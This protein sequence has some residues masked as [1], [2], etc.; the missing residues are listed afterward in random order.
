MHPDAL[1]L[2]T[3]RRCKHNNVLA[4]PVI[5]FCVVLAALSAACT[6][7]SSATAICLKDSDCPSGKCLA[8]ECVETADLPPSNV[9]ADSLNGPGDGQIGDADVSLAPC[10][11]AADCDGIVGGVGACAKWSC[12][13]GRC[14]PLKQADLSACKTA[15]TCPAAGFCS[16]GV[17]NATG[18]ICVDDNGCTID[19]CGNTGCVHQLFPKGTSCKPSGAACLVGACDSGGNCLGTVAPGFC[20]IDGVCHKQGDAAGEKPCSKCLPTT[21]TSKWTMHITGPCDDGDP[22]TTGEHCNASGICK[23]QPAECV[24]K[25]VCNLNACQPGVGCVSLALAG[26][27]TDSNPCTVD[28][29]CGSGECQPGAALNCDDANP[30]TKDSCALGFGC[31]HTPQPGPCAADADPCTEDACIGEVCIG[32]PVA[33]TCMIKGNCVPANGHPDGQPCLACKPD[34]SKSDWTA[35]NNE[36]CADGDACTVS[37]TC[38][39]GKCLGLVAVCEDKNPCTA[40]SCKADKGCVFSPIDASCSDGDACTKGDLCLAGGCAGTVLTPGTCDDGN[41]CTTDTCVAAFGCSNTPNAAPCSDGDPCTKFDACIAASCIA[42]SLICPCASDQECNDK[43]PCTVDTCV[44]LGCNNVPGTVLNCDDKNACTGPDLCNGAA[45]SG[46]AV[47]CDDK[48]PC[49]ADVCVAEVGCLAQPMQGQLCSDGNACT[50]ADVCIDGKC[51]GKLKNCDDGNACTLDACLAKSGQCVHDAFGDGTACPDDL[52]SCTSDECKSGVC[53]H[54]Q[55]KSDFCLIAGTCLSG[56]AIHPIDTCLGCLPKTSQTAWSPRTGLSCSDG[57]ICSTSDTCQ[58]GG[59]CTG[60]KLNCSD[61]SACTLDD[62]NPQSPK[63]PCFSVPTPGDCNDGSLCTT[64]DA[65]VQGKCTGTAV[66]CDDGNPCTVDGCAPL[67]GCSHNSASTGTPCVADDLPCTDNT[68]KD[69]ICT[70]KIAGGWCVITGL[71]RAVGQSPVGQPCL[72]CQPAISNSEWTQVTGTSCDDG[73]PC[74]SGDLCLAGKCLS[75]GG[76]ACDDGNPCTLDACNATVGCSHVVQV[77]TACNDGSACTSADVC[78]DGKCVGKAIACPTSA[79]AAAA[80]TVGVCD[81]KIGCTY[82]TVCPALH[83]CSGGQCLTFAAG[84]TTP[85]PVAVHIAAG[86]AATPSRPTLRWH[87]SGDDALGAVPRLWLAAQAKPCT[88]AGTTDTR[89]VVIHLSAA[90]APPKTFA[91]PPNGDKPA[92]AIFPQLQVHPASYAHLALAWL[93][94]DAVCPAG[95]ARLAVLSPAS[96]AYT[97][98]AGCLPSSSGRPAVALALA[99]T[100]DVLLPTAL[101]GRIAS[102]T[103]NAIWQVSGAYPAD[104]NSTG[105]AYVTPGSPLPP[106][107]AV[108]SVWPGR[109][110]FATGGQVTWLAT[111]ALFNPA[112]TSST[113]PTAALLLVKASSPPPLSG[114]V[115]ATDIDAIADKVT[116]WAAETAWDPESARIGTVVSGT[117]VQAGQP[118]GFLAWLRLNPQSTASV[119]PTLLQTFDAPTLDKAAVASFRVAEVPAS[120]DFLVAWAGVATSSILVARLKPIDDKKVLTVWTQVVAK[121][122]ASPVAGL[123]VVG[124]GGLS[125]L[126]VGPKADTFSLV[127]ETANGLSLVT[128][129]L[130]NVP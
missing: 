60:D 97:T 46:P 114:A 128:L 42:G 45:C 61:D 129:S 41:I 126:V 33:S 86:L 38:D 6:S 37:E 39:Q 70:A 109:G 34:K 108:A 11:T 118:R 5:T 15:A 71:C 22:C 122:F 30:C 57:N 25:N 19:S 68:C 121:D 113:P 35:L 120:P 54:S 55:V 69:S 115:A 31:L 13:E 73:N 10:V 107:E 91:V 103:T 2:L 52:V 48:N 36:P 94:R 47:L 80:C 110:T 102:A 116:Y 123:P 43:N 9:G 58:K 8:G 95:A 93:E 88:D 112:S 20:L 44:S 124:S 74:T 84:V 125:E 16:D 117:M 23:G 104:L 32:T 82:P 4:L 100:G 62:C 72:M 78:S 59:A 40:D 92:C 96:Q 49:T 26:T 29:N 99:G 79:D 89:L 81:A 77:G 127:Y 12:S 17:C 130:T 28:D 106:A 75:P 3:R 50:A 101:G 85:S 21:S 83:Q 119:T 24:A 64:S 1:P 111:P 90:G 63:A 105:A 65:C 66:P 56:G 67:T 7:V 51:T 53:L 18:P 98:S 14:I 27:C 87:D 76:S